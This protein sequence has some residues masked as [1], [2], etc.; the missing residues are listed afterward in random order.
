MKAQKIGWTTAACWRDMK[1]IEQAGSTVSYCTHAVR[2]SFACGSADAEEG[3][4]WTLQELT[5]VLTCAGFKR[6]VHLDVFHLQT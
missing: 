4:G 6:F 3:A 5:C 2:P 1:L